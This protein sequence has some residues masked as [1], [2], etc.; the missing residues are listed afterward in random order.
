[1]ELLLFP[2]HRIIVNNPTQNC[3]IKGGR[4]DW[5]GLPPD[6][7]LFHSKQGCGLPIGNLTSQIFANFYEAIK[8][9][10]S[11]G[12][13]I[14]RTAQDEQAVLEGD[15][16]IN[17]AD[18][19]R[20]L[21]DQFMSLDGNA[22]QKRAARQQVQEALQSAYKSMAQHRAIWKPILINI[23][24][25]ATGI[26]LLLLVAKMLGTKHA[27]WGMT[28]RQEQLLEIKKSLDALEEAKGASQKGDQ[29]EPPTYRE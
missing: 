27:F 17:L 16:A 26:G 21:A 2:C 23:A 12:K 14:K 7:S 6:K 13:F 29:P 25:A 19:L 20:P 4:T 10:R 11:R 9:V 1:M 5:Q 15:N 18:R 24:I 8:H 22:P 3:L 28:T